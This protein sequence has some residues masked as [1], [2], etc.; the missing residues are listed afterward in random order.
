MKTTA[1]GKDAYTAGQILDP[2]VRILRAY[3]KSASTHEAPTKE[4]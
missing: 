4:D 1:G 2:P 3:R